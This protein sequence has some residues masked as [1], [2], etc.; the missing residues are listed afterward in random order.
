MPPAEA[1]DSDNRLTTDQAGQSGERL[2]DARRQHHEGKKR[3]NHIPA[4]VAERQIS[5]DQNDADR[6]E[7]LDRRDHGLRPVREPAERE[8]PFPGIGDA[9]VPQHLALGLDCQGL[10]RLDAKDRLSQHRRFGSL[11]YDHVG[12][13]G[14]QRTQ[15][16]QNN[17]D[18]HQ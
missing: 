1:S 5:T 18:D 10:H 15:E 4:V 3:S 8:P 13:D 2:G 14:P 17:E 16:R 12:I 7:A 6:H 11:R 9:I